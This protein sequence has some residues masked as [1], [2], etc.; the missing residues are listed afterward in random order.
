MVLSS[1]SKYGLVKCSQ[2]CIIEVVQ[3][4]IPNSTSCIF[5]DSNP[6]ISISYR[7]MTM[8]LVDPGAGNQRTKNNKEKELMNQLKQFLE[9][10]NEIS[11]GIH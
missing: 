11:G 1:S 7:N 6:R 3:S 9:G 4:V 8:G 5:I 10:R 2:E